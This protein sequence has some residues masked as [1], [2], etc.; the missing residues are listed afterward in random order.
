MMYSVF[1]KDFRY[2]KNDS[3][4][5]SSHLQAKHTELL[6]TSKISSG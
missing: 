5:W 1:L 4:W 6:F 2:Q 3:S